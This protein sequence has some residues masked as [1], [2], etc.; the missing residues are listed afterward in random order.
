MNHNELSNVNEQE[1][2]EEQKNKM[3][4][5]LGTKIPKVKNLEIFDWENK[6]DCF[7]I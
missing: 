1:E 4:L 3:K 2:E 6:F 5:V 7:R